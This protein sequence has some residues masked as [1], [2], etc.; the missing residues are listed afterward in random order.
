MN[1]HGFIAFFYLL[2]LVKCVGLAGEQVDVIPDAAYVIEK[3]DGSFAIELFREFFGDH[4][5]RKY[6]KIFYT[7]DGNPI[8]ECPGQVRIED[9]RRLDPLAPHPQPVEFKIRWRT[10]IIKGVSG[11]FIYF[12]DKNGNVIDKFRCEGLN[13]LTA[14]NLKKYET[15]HSNFAKIHGTPLYKRDLDLSIVKNVTWAWGNP[16]TWIG[17]TQSYIAGTL[18]T[19]LF[20][21]A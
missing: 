2:S 18:I 16:L 1:Y 13:A 8:K 14:E 6:K 17:Y 20:F 5:K 9:Y 21:E 19:K 3:L 4:S 11:Y 15:D 10:V 12:Y 7:F